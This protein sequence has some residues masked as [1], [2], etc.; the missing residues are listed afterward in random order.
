MILLEEEGTYG[1]TQRCRDRVLCDQRGRKLDRGGLPARPNTL[2]DNL[3]AE[4]RLP[5]SPLPHQPGVGGAGRRNWRGFRPYKT[6]KAS[7]PPVCHQAAH[8]R[9][10]PAVGRIYRNGGLTGALSGVGAQKLMR[11]RPA[12]AV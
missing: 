6:K 7:G 3:G 4:I 1:K 9:E 2:N 8:T 12:A 5:P 10:S 11:T